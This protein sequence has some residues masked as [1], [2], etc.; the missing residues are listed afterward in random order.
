MNWNPALPGD[1][2]LP[3]GC[4]LAMIDAGTCDD[5]IPCC[6]GCDYELEDDDVCYAHDDPDHERPRCVD[7]HDRLAECPEC[8]AVVEDLDD[9][10]VI[11]HADVPYGTAAEDDEEA[12]REVH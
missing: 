8:E 12:N 11:V 9:H 2:S 10:M 1:P 4:T 3:P 6:V 7:C 5:D